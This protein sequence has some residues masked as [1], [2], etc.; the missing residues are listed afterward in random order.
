MKT[1]AVTFDFEKAIALL[2]GMD[3]LN[4]SGKVHMITGLTV[5]SAGPSVKIGE[6]CR[7]FTLRGDRSIQAEVVGFKDKRILLMPYGDLAGVGPGSRVVSTNRTLR[8]PV[9]MDVRGRVLDGLG[10]P[11]DGGPPIHTNEHYPVE[12]TPPNPLTRP[13]IHEVL[14]LG[15][16]AIDGLLT[17]G[18]GQRVGIFAGSGVGKSTLLGMIARNARSDVNVITLIGERGREVND[19]LQKDL[20]AE[21]LARSVIVVASSDQPALV[22]SKSALVGTSIAEYYRD[23]GLNVLLMMDSLTRYAMAQREIGMAVGEPPVSRGYTPSVYTVMPKLLERAGNSE[24]GSITALYTVLV[25]GDDLNEPITDT[26]RGILDGHIVLSRGLTNRNHYPAI[27]ILASVSRLMPDI[28]TKEHGQAAGR[29]K[30]LMAVYKDAE[31]LINIGAYKAGSNAE[32]D[33]AIRLH[34]DMEAILCQE[35]DET[36]AFADTVARLTALGAEGV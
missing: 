34:R 9:G 5:E 10:T 15:V 17:C 19:F 7:L 36:C 4:Y 21:G 2:R 24:K 1:D 35:V 3:S 32:I 29:M 31:D 6:M 33:E 23:R 13:R 16:R 8:V 18:R 28:V 27:D 26:A 12:N 14:P 30:R 22:R 20:K 25:E 11:I